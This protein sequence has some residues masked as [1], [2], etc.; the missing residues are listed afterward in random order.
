[1]LDR[2]LDDLYNRISDQLLYGSYNRNSDSIANIILKF[3]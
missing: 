2:L 1:M 3:Y